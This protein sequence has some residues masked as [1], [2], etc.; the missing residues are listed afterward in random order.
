MDGK[1]FSNTKYLIVIFIN[2]LFSEQQ[3]CL[4]RNKNTKEMKAYESKKKIQF[5]IYDISI[6]CYNIYLIYRTEENI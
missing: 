3:N 6:T 4:Y 1:A 2:R 5:S